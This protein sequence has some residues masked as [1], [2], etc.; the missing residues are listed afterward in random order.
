MKNV[1]ASTATASSVVRLRRSTDIGSW[2]HG[3]CV[4]GRVDRVRRG[5]RPTALR[6]E[7]RRT[8]IAPPRRCAVGTSRPLGARTMTIDIDPL[9]RLDGRTAIVTGGTR[10]IGRAVAEG[11][12][13]RRRQGRGGEPQ[14]RRLRGAPAALDRRAATRRIGVPTHLGSL[15]DVRRSSPRPSTASA[16]STSSSTTRRTRWPCR[17]AGSPRP[18][19]TSRSM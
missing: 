17:W 3:C 18:G 4:A 5:A 9:F 8:K 11:F 16:R 6:G 14:G 19:S 10:G 2:S 1:A 13:R 12:A 15:D 7:R